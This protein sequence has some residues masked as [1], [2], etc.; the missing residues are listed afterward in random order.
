MIAC[1]LVSSIVGTIV[2][3][4]LESI[5]LR[6]VEARCQRA[7]HYRSLGHIYTHHQQTHQ[8]PT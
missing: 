8:Y 7:A 2:L 3:A 4:N 1:S 6:E 5:V